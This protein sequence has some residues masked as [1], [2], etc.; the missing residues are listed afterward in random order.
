MIDIGIL[1]VDMPVAAGMLVIDIG[2]LVVDIGGCSEVVWW[3]HWLEK[4]FVVA[5]DAA[6]RT[7]PYTSIS[8]KR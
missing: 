6:M 7:A 2:M 8:F 5:K 1:V 4:G 3:V